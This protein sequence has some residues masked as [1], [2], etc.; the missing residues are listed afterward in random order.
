MK[1]F[2]VA[3]ALAT[4]SLGAGADDQV[5]EAAV[6]QVQPS[7]VIS[8]IKETPVPGIVEIKTENFDPIYMTNDGKYFLAGPLLKVEGGK[9]TN[10]TD[11]DVER[12]RAAV[13]ASVPLKDMIIFS[14]KVTKRR[15]YVFTDVDCAFCRKFHSQISDVT[16]LGIEVRYLAY[17]RAGN[18]SATA[19]TMNSVWCSRDRQ[20]ALTAAKAGGIIEKNECRTAIA[21]EHDMGASIGVKG[22]PAIFT[23][24]GLMLGGYLTPGQLKKALA[25]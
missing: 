14:P 19:V 8:S 5:L 6:K 17:P 1:A 25:L 23:E 9:I 10:L 15:I 16:D 11:Q 4:A 3:I 2:L 24:D 12:T 21:Q 13:F 22:T 20:Q 18:D 7:A